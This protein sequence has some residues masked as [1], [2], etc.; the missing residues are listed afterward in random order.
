MMPASETAVAAYFAGT[1]AGVTWA[2]SRAIAP[3]I[4]PLQPL[5]I[6]NAIRFRTK[7]P[8]QVLQ[9]DENTA[10]TVKTLS[11]HPPTETVADAAVSQLLKFQKMPADWDGFGAAKPVQVSV[12]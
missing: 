6:G 7:Q 4:R 5:P 3:H 1:D 9:E 8:T 10:G 2:A 11:A 12:D